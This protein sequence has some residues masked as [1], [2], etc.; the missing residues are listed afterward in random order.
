MP[1]E[2]LC[3]SIRVVRVL[4]LIGSAFWKPE[5]HGMLASLGH[6]REKSELISA[7]FLLVSFI[8]SLDLRPKTSA[9]Y[10]SIIV[11]VLMSQHTRET[12]MSWS[13]MKTVFRTLQNRCAISNFNAYIV[14]LM[15]IFMCSSTT[16]SQLHVEPISPVFVTRGCTMSNSSNQIRTSRRNSTLVLR[17]A[18]LVV[19]TIL[20][21][22]GFFVLLSI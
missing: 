16:Q 14:I 15:H 6:C 1:T 2:N 17:R 21:C 20:F 4:S 19:T 9:F 11:C 22:H 18:P 3:G 8:I 10:A 5:W 7:C 13:T 12:F